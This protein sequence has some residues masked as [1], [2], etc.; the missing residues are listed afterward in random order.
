VFFGQR[1]PRGLTTVGGP[2]DLDNGQVR[3]EQELVILALR[4]QLSR[5]L[6]RKVCAWLAL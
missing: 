2:L 5:G 6:P 4:S 3:G 1:A